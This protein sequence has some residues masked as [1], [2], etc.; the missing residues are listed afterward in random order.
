MAKLANV[1]I[2]TALKQQEITEVVTSLNQLRKLKP[3]KT[4]EEIEQR[5]DYYFNACADEQ[6]RPGIESLCLALGVTRTTLYRWANGSYCSER[7]TE[8]IQ[9]AKAVITSYIEQATLKGRL[10]PASS[11]FLFKNWAGYKDS[12]DVKAI[13]DIPTQRIRTIEEIAKDYP[14]MELDCPPS[15]ELPSI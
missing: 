2:E 11:C 5:L 3:V 10:N 13:S 7:R 6:I 12:Y 9:Q 4:D 1:E 14:D 8:L 15:A